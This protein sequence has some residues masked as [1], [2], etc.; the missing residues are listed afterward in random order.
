MIE[1]QLDRLAQWLHTP[2]KMVIIPHKNPDGDAMGSTLAWQNVMQQL[3]HTATEL[4]PNPYPRFLHWMP[5]HSDVV[6]YENEKE[7]GNKLLAEADFIF[8]LDFN[9][10]KRIF[11]T[12]KTNC[13]PFELKIFHS[14]N[15]YNRSIR[16]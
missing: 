13:F 5:G 9:T 1:T 2:S 12:V 14:C 16:C 15:F 11:L 7:K 3:G 8:T 6:I 4:A 10:L